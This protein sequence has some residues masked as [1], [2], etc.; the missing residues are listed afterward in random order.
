MKLREKIAQFCD[1]EKRAVIP[2]VTEPILYEIPLLLERPKLE[3]T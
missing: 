3:T 1:V 2:M